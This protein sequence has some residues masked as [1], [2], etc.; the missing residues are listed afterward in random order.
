[1]SNSRIVASGA[2]RLPFPLSAEVRHHAAAVGYGL[3]G[4][5]LR[6]TFR[7]TVR[8]EDLRYARIL[9]LKPCC[10]GDVVF[11]TALVREIR[12]DLPRAHLAYAV[13]KHS[14]PALAGAPLDEIVDL[15]HLGAR[16]GPGQFLDLVRTLRA[17]RYD[18]CFVLERSAILALAPL[19]AGIPVRVGIDSGGRG[20][21]LSVGV[22]P[23]PI[24]AESELYLDLLRAIGGDVVSGALAYRPSAEARARVDSVLRA[25]GIDGPF[26][27]LHAA[28]G[29][30]PGMALLRKRWPTAHFAALA[31]RII[32]GGASVVLLGSAEDRE[33]ARA[34]DAATRRL[35]D[36]GEGAESTQPSE[37]AASGRN[38]ADGADG[39]RIPATP[40]PSVPASAEGTKRPRLVNLC[41]Q[42][43]LDEVA[44]LSVCAAVYVGND[45]GPTHLAEA[46]G[47]NVVM[48]F[49]PS[50]PLLYGPRVKNAIAVTAGLWCS[51]CFEDGRVA[52]CANVRCMESI[53]VERVWREV[54][55][56]LDPDEPRR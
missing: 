53:P 28:G 1:M 31:R 21:S 24:R 50:D 29:I 17:G 20:F 9:I 51:P 54:A 7:R 56:F 4:R 26:V 34:V 39:G 11:S 44:A 33:T 37:N 18:A 47:A 45:S 6:R 19:L 48:L 36:T 22:S 15:G 35:A 42:L 49:G 25:H 32:G 13:G 43:S 10:L 40:R 3:L 38:Q 41:G 5:A 55:R 14:R 12:R 46:A 52:P 16:L 2:T 8:L 27:A 23:R 30:N